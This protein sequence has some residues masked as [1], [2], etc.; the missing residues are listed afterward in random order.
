MGDVPNFEFYI[1]FF[2][3]KSRLTILSSVVVVV[4]IVI[5]SVKTGVFWHPIT[6]LDMLIFIKMSELVNHVFNLK[7]FCDKPTLLTYFNYKL[8]L[9]NRDSAKWLFLYSR[10]WQTQLTSTPGRGCW[11]IYCFYTSLP[12]LRAEGNKPLKWA[13][14]ACQR[15]GLGHTVLSV[16]WKKIRGFRLDGSI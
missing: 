7:Y 14:D 6:F 1:V 9:E 12:A 4:D 13:A 10:R 3:G 5:I 2:V 8:G 16:A 11:L 15:P